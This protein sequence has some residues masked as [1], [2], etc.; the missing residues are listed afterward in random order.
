MGIGDGRRI[1][2]LC[3]DRI[4]V[5]ARYVVCSQFSLLKSGDGNGGERR[6]V[7]LPVALT[8]RVRPPAEQAK[9]VPVAHRD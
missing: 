8:K 9:Q 1:S 3:A 2:V 5:R 4:V 7:R 6:N